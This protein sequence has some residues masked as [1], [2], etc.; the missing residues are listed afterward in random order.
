MDNVQ[1]GYRYPPIIEMRKSPSNKK[2]WAMGLFVLL[3]AGFFLFSKTNQNNLGSPQIQPTPISTVSVS[4]APTSPAFPSS[5]PLSALGERT[6]TS[7]C[8]A[9]NGL[10]DKGCTPGAIIQGATKDQI[11][12][13]GYSKSVRNV[14]ESEKNQVYLEYGITS[15]QAGEYEVDHLIP[16]ELGGSNDISNLWPE[17]AQPVPGFHEKDKVE[18]YLHA[19]VCSGKISLQEAQLGIV[20]NWEEFYK[21]AP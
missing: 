10:E 19:Q 15:R 1:G 13:S 6:K 2:W 3:I 7:G 20:N 18:N 5:A 4:L 16:L 17:A 8:V 14:P 21:V 12:I 11:C 9:A